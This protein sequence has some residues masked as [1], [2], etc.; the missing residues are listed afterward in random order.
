[1]LRLHCLGGVALVGAADGVRELVK[2]A[3]AP[4][5]AGL[6]PANTWQDFPRTRPLQQLTDIEALTSFSKLHCLP[7]SV[8]AQV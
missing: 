5:S 2:A 8:L 4:G 6:K 7:A 1:M 3:G